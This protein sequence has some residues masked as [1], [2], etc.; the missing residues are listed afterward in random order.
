MIYKID[1]EI[2][3]PVYPTEDPTRVTTAIESIFPTA[4]VEENTGEVTA[5]THSIDRFS[6][7]LAK[8]RIKETARMVLSEGTEGEVIS[9]RL[10]KQAALANVVNFAVDEGAELGDIDVRIRVEQP[11]PDRLIEELTAPTEEQD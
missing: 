8:Q 3:A 7:L 6:E 10:S 1:V 2:V 9:F 4:E 5:V 11:T